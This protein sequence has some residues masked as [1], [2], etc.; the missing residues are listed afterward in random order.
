MWSKDVTG[1]CAAAPADVFAVLAEPRAWPEWNDGV[2]DIRMDG[3]FQAG[4]SAVMVLPDG[5]ELPF[6]LAWVEADRGFEDVTAVPDAGVVVRVRH[7]LEPQG[8]GTRI[9]YRC[10]V[11]GPDEAAREVGTV[12]SADFGEVIA[13][14]G[15][16]AEAL[17]G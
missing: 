15:A 9:T 10:A 1:E 14:L 12:V 17:R 4:T 6:R 8:T 3:P 11:D 16:R 7:E 2:A 5:T 13:A